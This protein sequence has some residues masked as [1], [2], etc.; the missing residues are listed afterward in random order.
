MA[1]RLDIVPQAG[2]TNADLLA[3][4]QSGDV[5]AEN[6]W[7]IADRQNHGRGRQGR[8]W[9]DAPGNFMGSTVVSISAHDPS[10]SSLSF[11]TALAVYETV[12]ARLADPRVLQLKWPNDLLLGGRKLCGILLEREGN[13]AVVGVGVNLAAA[14]NVAD[15]ETSAM[16]QLGA[17]PDRDHFARQLAENFALELSRWRE[18]G[19]EPIFNRWQAAAH[20]V[21]TRLLVHNHVGTRIPGTFEGLEA[22]GALRLRLD[23]GSTH[24]IHAGDVMLGSEDCA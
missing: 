3:R 7:L 20:P 22:D 18:F 4:L 21:G 24:V 17:L 9:L 13:H 11:V 6:Y 2:S 19:T 8:Q 16:S 5:I 1:P 12:V 14:P 23:D 15:R 10:P